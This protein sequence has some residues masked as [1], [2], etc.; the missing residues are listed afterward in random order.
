MTKKTRDLIVG[1]GGGLIVLVL[2]LMLVL[3]FAVRN[4]EKEAA[5]QL[6]SQQEV[7]QQAQQSQD[8]PELEI[9]TQKDISITISA[10]GDCTFATDV[11]Y[12]GGPSFVAK[13]NEQQNPAYFLAGVQSL[14]ANDD[15]TIVNF[16]GTLTN[17]NTRQDKQFAFRGD[18]S[19][20]NI[21]T[22]GSVE[23]VNLANNHSRDYGMQSLA[24]TKQY[25]SE[26]GV[27]HFG[28]EETAI[29]ERKG[30]KIGLIGIYV[31]P[32]GLGRMQQ[33]KDHIQKVK[34][35]GAVITI[36][37]FHWGIEREYYP[38]DVQKQLAHAAIDNG[39]DLVIGEH[40]HVIQGIETYNGKKIVYSMGNFCFG[41]NKN[42]SDKDS[43]VVQQT[44][45]IRD[46][47]ILH[48]DDFKVIPCSISSVSHVNDY[49]PTILTGAEAE[50]V[51][52]KIEE[53][54]ANL[55]NQ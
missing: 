11:N 27:T 48:Y 40:P 36:V 17:L 21:L 19:Y 30:V 14:F 43:M 29:V 33:L 37:N 34:Q 49:Q 53:I 24:D 39:A 51:M 2:V 28:Y 7:Q 16:E 18:P 42:P 23:A 38:N 10:A 52:K 32:D 1:I 20:V 9:E 54:S 50:R 26:A 55:K 5:K 3:F 22:Q 15:L 31:L 4:K 12:A 45:T 25:L 6:E 8:L 13:Y 46:G 47:K 44:F 41:G 35:E